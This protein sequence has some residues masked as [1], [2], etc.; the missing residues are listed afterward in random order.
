MTD[1]SVVLAVL[2]L[3]VSLAVVL[4]LLVMLA[5]WAS[6]RGLGSGRPGRSTVEVEVLSRR[7]LGKASTL[8]V[9]KVG[10]QVMVLG[11]TDRGVTVLGELGDEDVIPAT[12]PL[13]VVRSVLPAGV[14]SIA[15]A[16][17][18]GAPVTPA[19]HPLVASD[20][21]ASAA[22]PFDPSASAQAWSAPLTAPVAAPA[23]T[24][25][26][27]ATW[28]E[29]E[30]RALVAAGLQT[31]SSARAAR[32]ASRA[33]RPRRLSLGALAPAARPRRQHPSPQAVPTLHA[34]QALQSA[35][36]LE[37]A[38][39]LQSAQG[40]HSVPAASALQLAQPAQ[41]RLSRRSRTIVTPVDSRATRRAAQAPT[42]WPWN[43]AAVVLGATG[44]SRRG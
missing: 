25:A 23:V 27:S 33:N 36:A 4:V 24:P 3:L 41:S 35:Q 26:R 16:V 38:Q 2:R 6:K 32:E 40:L 21:G 43:A 22:G 30:N 12:P 29:A 13:S 11:V 8:Q 5:R 39:G 37:S 34:I 28:A 10:S 44:I 31:R 20:P 18:P 19:A 1:G 15:P 9:V 14:S 7:S 42:G 17:S